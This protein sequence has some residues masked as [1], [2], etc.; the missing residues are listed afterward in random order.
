MTEA[1]LVWTLLIRIG[2]LS[3]T[4]SYENSV[5]AFC[6]L[7]SSQVAVIVSTSAFVVQWISRRKLQLL[8]TLRVC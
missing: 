8:V 5:V 2:G 1:F 7:N 4:G 6:I 3:F